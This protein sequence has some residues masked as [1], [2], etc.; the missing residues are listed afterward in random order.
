VTFLRIAT[1]AACLVLGQYLFVRAAAQY[2]SESLTY[3]AQLFNN[4]D[5]YAQ[6][7]QY[8]RVAAN[9]NPLNGYAQFHIA[10]SEYLLDRYQESAD[11]CTRALPLMPHMATLLR[12]RGECYHQ[13]RKFPEAAADLLTFLAMA[14]QP[15]ANGGHLMIVAAQSLLANKRPAEAAFWL[16]RAGADKSALADAQINKAQAAVAIGDAYMLGSALMAV[17]SRQAE[18]KLDGPAL[19]KHAL[20]TN[21]LPVALQGLSLASS[22]FPQSIP[23]TKT[24]AAGY[25]RG[26]DP[27]GIEF[28]KKAI[29][30]NEQDSELQ[31]MLGDLYFRLKQFPDATQQFD[32][33]LTINPDSPYRVQIEQRKSEMR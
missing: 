25:V 33:V 26:A 29:A 9:L 18:D 10:T 16:N 23:V 30:S 13:L 12:Q 31:F 14:P 24:L 6:G 8:A 5:R 1:V 4:R 20:A 3:E 19:L 22:A 21:R 27:A 15:P 11:Q 28:L 2:F 7:E 17:V 32:R